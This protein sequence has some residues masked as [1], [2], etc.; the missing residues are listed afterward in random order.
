[1]KKRDWKSILA[2]IVLV[3][4][5][6]PIAYLIYRLIVAPEINS[7]HIEG[8]RV[9]ADY[10]LMI[11]QC[12]LGILAMAIPSIVSKKAKII[13]PSNMY[14]VFLLFLYCAIFLGEVT[15]FYYK[16]EYWD[17]MLHAISSGMLGALGF[18][19]IDLLNKQEKIRMELSPMFVTLFAFCFAVT[20]GA[21]WEIYEFTWDGILNLN[22]QKYALENGIQLVGRAALQDTM[23]DII[24]DCI[25][26]FIMSVI[27][28]ISLKY[29]KEWLEKVLI[30]RKSS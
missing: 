15:S 25:G 18:S 1:M 23:K 26:A 5:I 16:F 20:L 3:S 9:K 30:K 28:Y 13:I 2:K 7:E 29:K 27:G 24:V 4:F 22:M 10:A 8:L 19:L 6:I 12:L 17:V 11:V 21:I 14:I